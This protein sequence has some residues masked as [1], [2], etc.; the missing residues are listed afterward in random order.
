[1]QYSSDGVTWALVSGISSSLAVDVLGAATLGQ[2]YP[3]LVY[4]KGTYIWFTG[5]T[6]TAASN[7]IYW[8]NESSI[9]TG[10]VA[11]ASNV[12]STSLVLGHARPDPGDGYGP[13]V[14]HATTQTERKFLRVNVS[15]VQG[16]FQTGSFIDSLNEIGGGVDSPNAALATGDQKAV[17]FSSND[18]PWQGLY[19]NEGWYT[20]VFQAQT[21]RTRFGTAAAASNTVY[22]IGV[23]RWSDNEFYP[24]QSRDESY[25]DNR[26][27]IFPQFLTNINTS[28]DRL[29]FVAE[30]EQQGKKIVF[31][32]GRKVAVNSNPWGSI[33]LIGSRAIRPLR[34][35]INEKRV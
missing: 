5:T 13:I 11:W 6:S 27:S 17:A 4:S 21:N 24:G 32:P 20:S 25:P 15:N 30:W 12:I 35:T 18:S 33:V 14:S 1:M 19:Y 26:V 3:S 8:I 2:W 22:S 28:N 7:R 34:T 31:L 23:S 10:S 16:N 29:A 9:T